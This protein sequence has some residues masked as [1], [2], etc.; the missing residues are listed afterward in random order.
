NL[1]RILDDIQANI[2]RIAGGHACIISK[3]V[4]SPD[5]NALACPTCGAP[6]RENQVLYFQVA[7]ECPACKTL[8]YLEIIGDYKT[9][10]PN[11]QLTFQ[12]LLNWNLELRF[13]VKRSRSADVSASRGSSG[14]RITCPK[15][16]K[17]AN[18]KW[19]FCKWCG[20][21]LRKS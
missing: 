20:S 12:Q 17:I 21:S 7:N 14:W 8:L 1:T 6:M 10:M 13:N 2:K 9:L 19:K 16:G 15:C 4:I 11:F 5:E 3:A 18:R